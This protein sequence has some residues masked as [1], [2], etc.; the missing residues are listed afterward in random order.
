MLESLT[1]L[2]GLIDPIDG[3]LTV[4]EWKERAI[5]AEARLLRVASKATA[6]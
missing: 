2:N 6:L 5:Q 1:H 4:Q 3:L